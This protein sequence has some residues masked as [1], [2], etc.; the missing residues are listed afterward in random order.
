[1]ERRGE[2]KT[3]SQVEAKTAIKMNEERAAE[4]QTANGEEEAKKRYTHD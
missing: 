4:K 1:M 2:Y 3:L